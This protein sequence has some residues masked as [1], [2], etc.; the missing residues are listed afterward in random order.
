M[1]DINEWDYHA[2]F[3]NPYYGDLMNMNFVRNLSTADSTEF[4]SRVKDLKNKLKQEEILILLEDKNWRSTKVGAWIIRL[5]KMQEF[6]AA[7]IETLQT[8]YVYAE[9]L[10]AAIC[11]L[12]P[13]KGHTSIMNY[14]DRQFLI[15]IFEGIHQLIV[16]ADLADF[17]ILLFL[18]FHGIKQREIFPRQFKELKYKEKTASIKKEQIDP[19]EIE[20]KK[21]YM[22]AVIENNQLYLDPELS[23]PELAKKVSMK[24]HELSYFLNQH[25][26]QNFYNFI[27][28][29]RIEESKKILLD[30]DKQHLSIL[31]V[32]LESGFNSKTAFNTNFKKLTDLSPS[33]FK[34]LGYQKLDVR[35]D[36]NEHF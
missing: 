16:F 21:A 22:L 15:A 6:Q 2:K 9:H 25:F 13:E 26:D 8:Q 31:G 35:L 12:D 7:L 34:K 4:L 5:N 3:I 11:L 18:G 28:R 10:I 1:S 27:N 14:L 33:A 24:T 17:F 32:A 30:P 19:T 23:L 29:F 20:E 36:T